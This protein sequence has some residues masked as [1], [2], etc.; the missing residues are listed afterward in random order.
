MLCLAKI[1]S[2]LDVGL[3][4]TSALNSAKSISVSFLYQGATLGLNC[5]AKAEV[6]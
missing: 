6:T 3:F 5:E 1:Y 2:G 4:V